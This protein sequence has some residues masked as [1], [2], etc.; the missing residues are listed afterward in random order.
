M[1]LPPRLEGLLSKSSPNRIVVDDPLRQ[2]EPILKANS[3][4][5]FPDYNDH[6]I[7]HIEKVCATAE[8]LI[9]PDAWKVFS[10]AD[11]AVLIF[12]VLLHDLAMHVTEDQFIEL[13]T[14]DK[15]PVVLHTQ[16]QPWPALWQKFLVEARRY[17]G[18]KL[19]DLFGEPEP[20]RDPPLDPMSMT[21]KD[22]ML[23]GEFLRQHHARLAHEH[24]L[25]GLSGGT[26]KI[27]FDSV[28]DEMRD[29]A[30]LVARS[31]NEPLRAM[32]PYLDQRY[33]KREFQGVH[34]IYLG[35]LL[36][37]ADYLQIEPGPLVA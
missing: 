19:K 21:K 17:D 20:V 4:T 22:R 6:G 8:A 16:D 26:G 5:F 18:R 24:A 32:I 9:T 33:D 28:P 29:L 30:G 10:D 2:L 35:G 3:L 13:V 27:T 14:D 1:Q 25:Y 37:I 31:H 34:P 12:S 11:A 7:D 15:R 23:I 36:R